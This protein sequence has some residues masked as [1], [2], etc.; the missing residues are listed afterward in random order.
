VLFVTAAL[1]ALERDASVRGV[2][3]ASGVKKYIFTAGCAWHAA[4]EAESSQRRWQ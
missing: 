2:I 3:I 4:E 1:D